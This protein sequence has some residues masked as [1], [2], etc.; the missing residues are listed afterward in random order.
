MNCVLSFFGL[1]MRNKMSLD[2]LIQLKLIIYSFWLIIKHQG[3]QL[4]SSINLVV[5]TVV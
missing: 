4:F 2:S 1:V 5:T 3:V